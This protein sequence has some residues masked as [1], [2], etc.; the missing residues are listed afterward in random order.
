MSSTATEQTVKTNAPRPT[1]QSGGTV[2][3]AARVGPAPVVQGDFP[4]LVGTPGQSEYV[5]LIDGPYSGKET[6]VLRGSQTLD[7]TAL[8]P[9]PTGNTFVVAHYDR[10]SDR[11]ADGLPLFRFRG[12]PEPEP[13]AE[14]TGFDAI[15]IEPVRA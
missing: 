8:N 5:L 10:T 2:D 13:E 14:P 9:F 6:K 15:E 3:R 1:L 11:S 12:W 7:Q 4:R